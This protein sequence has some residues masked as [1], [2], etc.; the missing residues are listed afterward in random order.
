LERRAQTFMDRMAFAGAYLERLSRDVPET[1]AEAARLAGILIRWLEDLVESPPRRSG[2]PRDPNDYVHV[3]IFMASSLWELVVR[4]DQ[5]N[6]GNLLPLLPR[7]AQAAWRRLLTQHLPHLPLPAR[8]HVC[9]SSV[10]FKPNGAE[11]EARE[12]AAL[13]ST[14][15]VVTPWFMASD[16]DLMLPTC[17]GCR[18][19]FS[20]VVFRFFYLVAL[21]E[22]TLQPLFTEP[23]N[24]GPRR[25]AL[26]AYNMLLSTFDPQACRFVEDVVLVVSVAD[27]KEA[28]AT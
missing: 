19:S 5:R 7:P 13:L 23:A 9:I 4:M 28:K 1:P 20:H 24:R 25:L 11:E 27:I 18:E 17:C 8:I 10:L 21:Q 16:A 6:A 14:A 2:A 22:G 3:C 26:M 15:A 12:K